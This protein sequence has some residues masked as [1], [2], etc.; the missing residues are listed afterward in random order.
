MSVTIIKIQHLTKTFGADEGAVQTLI[1]ALETDAV[2]DFI[3]EKYEGA[4]V[5]VF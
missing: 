1:D 3:L 4:V 5:P 2:R